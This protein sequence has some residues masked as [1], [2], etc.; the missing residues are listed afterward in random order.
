MSEAAM[1][2][3]VRLNPL[4]KR[5]GVSRGTIYN[6][7]AAGHFPQ[8]VNLGDTAM[9]FYEDEIAEWQ[10]ERERQSL[11]SPHRQLKPKPLKPRAGFRQPSRPK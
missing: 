11:A 1:R 8:P 2:N 6:W 5:L 3:M 9:A 7:M 4:A 10:K